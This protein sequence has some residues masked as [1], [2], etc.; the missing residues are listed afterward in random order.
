MRDHCRESVAGDVM[1]TA[2]SILAIVI[3][4]HATDAHAQAGVGAKFGTHNPRT[5]PSR[6]QPA[7]GAISAAQAKQ[8]FICDVEAV[9]D[10]SIQ[11]VANV[12]VQV[13]KGRPFNMATDSH[14]L[15]IDAT[16][17]VYPIRGGFTTWTCSPAGYLGS[18]PK[19]NCSFKTEQPNAE[20]G[21]FKNSF[22]DWHCSMLDGKT[23]KTTNA[24]PGTGGGA[25]CW[26]P[27]PTEL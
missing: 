8:Y 17:T 23:Q 25:S 27:P 22:G 26:I 9:S 16:Q 3:A 7:S 20:G 18:D 6:Q 13:G 14:W 1:K 10:N 12:T 2:I 4:L 5:C 11:L 19:R 21:C 24:C 15:N